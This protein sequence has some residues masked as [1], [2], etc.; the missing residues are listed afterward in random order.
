MAFVGLQ[1]NAAACVRS[2]EVAAPEKQE[3][4]ATRA[5]D[6]QTSKKSTNRFIMNLCQF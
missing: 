1:E 5:W 4:N 6:R 2:K 3:N